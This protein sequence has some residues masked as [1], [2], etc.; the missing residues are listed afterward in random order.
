MKTRASQKTAGTG[1]QDVTKAMVPSGSMSVAYDLEL[2]RLI[3]VSA[4]LR[5]EQ[6]G[7]RKSPDDYWFAAEDEY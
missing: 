7:F 1:K 2:H 3:E 6:D 4:Y 5:A